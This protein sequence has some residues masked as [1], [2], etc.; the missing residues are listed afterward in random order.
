MHKIL[1]SVLWLAL[2]CSFG[3]AQEASQNSI[4]LIVTDKENNF[5]GDMKKEEIALFID[6]KEHSNFLIDK[7]TSPLIYVLAVDSSGSMRSIFGDI[8][9]SAKIM[10]SQNNQNDLTL[11]MRFISSD[12]IQVTDKFSSDEKYL[13]S[14]LNLFAVEGGQTAVIDAIFKSVQTVAE[15]EGVGEDYRRSVVVVSDGEDRDSL[16]TQEQLIKLLQKEKVQ[17]FFIGLINE[18]DKEGGFISKSPREKSKK[19]IQKITEASGGAAIYPK[20]I[21]QLPEIAK[22][23]ISLLRTQYILKF[24]LPDNIKKSAKIEIRS[25]KSSKRKNLNFHFRR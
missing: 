4:N 3:F 16:N 5:V 25:A 10:V 1:I 21:E 12:K 24:Q 15:Q 7:Q 8:L 20:K 23:I 11:L 22:Q 17:I 14:N 19:F 6:G 18:L 13:H 2:I 9:N